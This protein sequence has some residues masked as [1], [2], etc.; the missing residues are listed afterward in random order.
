MTF[1]SHVFL[2]KTVLA[3]FTIT[4][5]VTGSGNKADASF[6]NEKPSVSRCVPASVPFSNVKKPWKLVRK[7]CDRVKSQEAFTV[8]SEFE[9][10]VTLPP[11]P[12]YDS[13]ASKL[14]SHLNTF[15]RSINSKSGWGKPNTGCDPIVDDY[16]FDCN[17]IVTRI[18]RT[19]K[20]YQVARVNAFFQGIPAYEVSFSIYVKVEN[21]VWE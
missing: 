3:I 11:N 15:L 2:R 19:T 10:N 9:F 1:M 17:F 12:S 18:N 6:L 4:F 7:N 14:K 5:L 8:F 20:Q 21:G 16:Y 13:R